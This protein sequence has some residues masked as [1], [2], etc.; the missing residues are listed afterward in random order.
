MFI[1]DALRIRQEAEAVAMATGIAPPNTL[2]S[3]SIN[4]QAIE[5]DQSDETDIVAAANNAVIN[6]EKSVEEKKESILKSEV[7][8]SIMYDENKKPETKTG[9]RRPKTVQDSGQRKV[10]FADRVME[11]T[12]RRA[13]SALPRLLPAKSSE[14][15]KNSKQRAAS[16]STGR[17]KPGEEWKK[18]DDDEDKGGDGSPG[19]SASSQNT[20]SGAVVVH[21]QQ[22]TQSTG[23]TESGQ[24]QGQ[25]KDNK[26]QN[27]LR[28]SYNNV[29]FN[30]MIA[31]GD[32]REVNPAASLTRPR[33]RLGCWALTQKPDEDLATLAVFGNYQPG[34]DMEDIDLY[35]GFDGQLSVRKSSDQL[36]QSRPPSAHN[37]TL[38][39]DRMKIK[40][41]KRP[42]SAITRPVEACEEDVDLVVQPATSQGKETETRVV[43]RMSENMKSQRPKSGITLAMTPRSA[44]SLEGQ[45]SQG[46]LKVSGERMSQSMKAGLC[47]QCNRHTTKIAIVAQNMEVLVCDV[48]DRVN[49]A[50]IKKIKV[51]ASQAMDRDLSQDEEELDAD[52]IITANVD[53]LD[54]MIT[55][56]E[57]KKKKTEEEKKKEAQSQGNILVH[58]CY[59]I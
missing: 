9:K 53:E 48:C 10:H 16:A 34:P 33:S 7:R 54:K 31:S 37:A 26:D 8:D 22:T 30:D 58:I 36:R 42:I 3:P 28:V 57:E 56:L 41:G 46:R 24:G 21:T 59:F 39:S 13:K 20:T 29:D 4:G 1:R 47:T 51:L 52:E 15:T 43:G 14:E 19:N 45:S 12:G 32:D 50:K 18:K 55:D 49:K 40:H 38:A 35:D 25:T 6:A 44:A 27:A 2:E 11:D 5:M 23:T 17:C